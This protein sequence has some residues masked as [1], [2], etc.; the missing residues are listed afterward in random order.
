MVYGFCFRRTVSH[1]GSSGVRVSN[2]E[3]IWTSGILDSAAVKEL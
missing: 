2:H 3:L 1:T